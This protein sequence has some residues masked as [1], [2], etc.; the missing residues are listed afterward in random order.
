ML[1]SVELDS[2]RE[3]GYAICTGL[4][5]DT[6]TLEFARTIGTVINLHSVHKAYPDRL[7]DTLRPQERCTS[8]LNYYH[9]N[10]GFETYPAHTD[11]AHWQIPP[12]F[13]LLRGRAGVG[14]VS[15]HVYG[16][17]SLAEILPKG[18]I[19]RAIFV[20]RNARVTTALRMNISR[21]EEFSLRWDPLFI[22]PV[23]SY[24]YTCVEILISTS[25]EQRRKS[26]VLGDNLA[27]IIDNW[28]ALHGRSTVPLSDR[29]RMIE[30]VYLESLH[31]ISS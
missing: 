3:D 11:L 23:N 20:P 12:R 30:R 2:L 22:R 27:L 19:K 29:T 5:R 16:T 26:F 8:R 7:V 31:G 15:T 17:R 21:F 18:Q 9:G 10:Y 25:L 4:N 28:R 1:G 14:H 24:A 6:S 13:L